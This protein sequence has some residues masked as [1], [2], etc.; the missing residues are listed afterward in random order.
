[1]K[2]DPKH[3]SAIEVIRSEASMTRAAQVLGTSQPALSRMV[4]DLEIRLGAPLFDRTTRPWAL[5]RLGEALARQGA[6]VLRAQARASQEFDAFRS[7]AKGRLRIAGTPFIT[8][9]VLAP[10][11]PGF[12]ARFPDVVFDLSYG[13]ADE[14]I[15][16]VR[17][18]RADLSVYP[19]GVGEALEDLTFTPLIEGRNVIVCRA[20][21]P[22]LRLAFP[23]PLALLDYGWVMPPRGSP[24]AADMASILSE[25]QMHEAEIVLHGGSLAA[26]LGYIAASDTL[27]V[28]PEAVALTMGPIHG[29]R[30]VPIETRTPAARW[31]CCRA[32]RPNWA[33]R[34]APSSDICRAPSALCS[35]R[36][37]PAAQPSSTMPLDR[38]P[39]PVI[40]TS[41][42]MP[43][44]RNSCGLR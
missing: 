24:L 37:M 14:L 1:V 11:L 36:G 31:A 21:H 18:G 16:A 32:P 8:D 33:M 22:I 39:M 42:A 35:R 20:Q 13:Y 15:E 4:S 27:T 7:G 2:I 43:G 23:R 25:L 28:L 10:M 29:L 9:G 19:L 34:R 30:R 41:T 44:S 40:S 38:V 12:R 17:S 6:T 26:V 3:L 5:T